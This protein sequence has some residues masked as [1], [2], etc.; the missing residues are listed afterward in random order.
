MKKHLTLFILFLLFFCT[1]FS[2]T[3]W[4]QQVDY[5]IDVSLNDSANTLDGN[6]KMDYFN[7]SPD[8]LHFIWIEL[9]PNAFKNDRT[10]FSDQLLENGRTDFYF[11]D[12]D[13]R[14]YINRLNF[15]VDGITVKAE[16]HPQHQDIIKILLPQSLAP[17]SSIKI[18]TPFHV[19]LP[20]NFSGDGYT[21]RSYQITQWFPK[22]AVYDKKGW[23]EMPYLVQ[24]GNYNE[25]GNYEVQITAPE[26][27]TV[28]AS[29]DLQNSESKNALKTW[30]FQLNN[31][32]DFVWFADKKFLTKQEN[33]QLASGKNI[34]INI[35]YKKDSANIWTNSIDAVKKAL[36]EKSTLIDD[37]PYNS[38]S[39]VENTC[40]YNYTTSYPSIGLLKPL[41]NEKER[42]YLLNHLTGANWFGSAIA[43]N[44]QRELWLSKGLNAYY[45]DKYLKDRNLTSLELADIKNKFL[46]KRLPDNSAQNLLRTVTGIDQDQPTLTRTDSLTNFN[47]LLLPQ[48]GSNFVKSLGTFDMDTAKLSVVLKEFYQR[49]K[50]KHP[51]TED[52]K[53]VAEEISKKD[54]SA[55]FS[56]L[57]KPGYTFESKRIDTFPDFHPKYNF[58]KKLKL[59]SFFSFKE[60]NKYNY[61]FLSPA[62]GYN[63][64]DKFMIGAAIHNYTLPLS[65]FDFFATP[66]YGTGSK[67][68]TGIGRLDYHL[69]PHNLFQHIDISLSGATFTTDQN[70]DTAGNTIYRSFY[71]IVPGIRFTFRKNDPRST[72]TKYI[73]F[74]S[75]FIQEQAYD[76]PVDTTINGTDTSFKQ[77]A[78]TIN[79]HRLLN[80]LMFVV[81]NNRALY[82]YRAEL[83]AEQDKG[84]IRLAFT[85]N[86]F[87]NY[88]H[89]K[90]G[91]AVRLFAGKFFYTDRAT[92]NAGLYGFSLSAPRGGDSYNSKGGDYTYSNYFIGRNY[93]P[94]NVSGTDWQFFYQQVMIK[95][96]GFKVNTDAMGNIESDDWLA[97]TNIVF[98]VP[99]NINPLSVLPFKIPLKVFLDVG[100]YAEPWANNSGESKFLYDAGLQLSLA[101]GVVNIYVP[102][103]YSQVFSDYYSSVIPDNG[104]FFK[105]ISFSIDLQNIN[106]RKII[107]QLSY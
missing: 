91:V 74:K 67:K 51:T 54:L 3:Y 6:V 50:F 60:T 70:I 71:K 18:E 16:D 81:E 19:K 42:S 34:S 59:A 15:K 98:D 52:F 84:F 12:D 38:I 2:Q 107:P 104:R 26:K 94:F 41:G 103:L 101:K 45:D 57:N 25:F 75:F 63:Y 102:I 61:I 79:Q 20:Y 33:I 88:A 13:K 44:E 105:T 69:Y 17:N 27:Y 106:L 55:S 66:M 86:Y 95:D 83:K 35:Y 77:K 97:A 64:Y 58:N 72:I 5:K 11:S 14:G 82:P 7:N 39:I 89:S 92:A 4:Q 22:P 87:F 32:S 43:N 85:G 9:W 65:K 68:L 56:Y 36:I 80:Q 76:Y 1:S 90:G 47:Y 31:G 99:K 46:K 28:A 78:I 93:Y 73:Q 40:K 24:G 8:T 30:H 62:I 48:K 96:G 49:W 10:A 23:H 21:G 29:G 53:A 100:T 37:Y